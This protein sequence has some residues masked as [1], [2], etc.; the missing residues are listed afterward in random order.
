MNLIHIHIYS[1]LEVI[2][3]D[4]KINFELFYFQT[5]SFDN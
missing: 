4:I 5:N 1:N 2:L 3:K